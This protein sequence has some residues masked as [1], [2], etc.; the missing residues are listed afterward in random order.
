MDEV[1]TFWPE[2]CMHR[3]DTDACVQLLC[4]WSLEEQSQD[5]KVRVSYSAQSAFP[6]GLALPGGVMVAVHC[7]LAVNCIRVHGLHSSETE[8]QH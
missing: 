8:A 1:L 6:V 2:D 3:R 7:C 5:F 4:T